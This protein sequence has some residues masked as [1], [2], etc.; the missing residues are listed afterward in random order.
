M[1]GNELAILEMV[2]AGLFPSGLLLFL[3]IRIRMIEKRNN[4]QQ[5][6]PGNE[7]VPVRSATVVSPVSVGFLVSCLP[8]IFRLVILEP[9]WVYINTDIYQ[10]MVMMALMFRAVY[11]ALLPILIVKDDPEL[12][13]IIKNVWR[14]QRNR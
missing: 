14:C 11:I 4:N 7:P 10:N 5:W 2:L 9:F 8:D 13:A 12:R 3:I 1:P 6:R